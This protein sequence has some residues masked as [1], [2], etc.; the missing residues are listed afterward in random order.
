MNALAK[1]I[2]SIFSFPTVASVAVVAVLFYESQLEPVKL[3]IGLLLIP[4]LPLIPVLISAAKG[5]VDLDVSARE[6]R[7]VFFAAALLLMLFNILV[8]YALDWLPLLKLSIAYLV[9][10][11]ATAIITLKWKISIHTAALAG[12][13]TYLSVLYGWLWLLPSI[14]ALLLLIWARV[15]LRAHTLLQ[16]VLG[17]LVAAVVALLCGLAFK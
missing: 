10:T 3:I 2:S 17:A 13:A 15:R 14:P 11:L 16:A 5:V 8:F 9:V 4:W 12:P 7:P 6:R 1:T